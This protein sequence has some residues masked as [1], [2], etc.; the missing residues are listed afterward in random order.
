MALLIREELFPTVRFRIAYDYLKKRHSAT[1]AARHYLNILYLA[2]RE[3]E[4]KVD[5][6]LRELIDNGEQISEENVRPRVKA[7]EGGAP[8][9][10]LHIPTVDLRCYDA[11]LKEVE[12]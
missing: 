4:L 9:T 7:H 10:D 11:L 3:S 12:A 8:L 6:A 2:A 5:D 1:V